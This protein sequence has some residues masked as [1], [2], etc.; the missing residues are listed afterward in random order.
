MTKDN[1]YKNICNLSETT[2]LYDIINTT[3]GY[4]V[5]IC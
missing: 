3:F 1:L 5:I 2:P 4:K